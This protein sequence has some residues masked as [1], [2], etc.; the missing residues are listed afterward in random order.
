MSAAELKTLRDLVRNLDPQRL[1]TASF[2]GHDL[3]RDDLRES[4]VTV[5]VDFL[6]PHRPRNAQSPGQTEA[7]TRSRLAMMKEIGRVVPV[8]HQEPFRRGYSQWEPVAGDFLTDLRGAIAGGAAGWCFHNGQQRDTPDKEPRRSFDLRTRRLFDQLDAEELKV[9]ADARALLSGNGSGP[10]FPLKAGPTKR[11]LVDQTGRP[12]FINGDTPWS[13]ASRV[14]R[15]DVELYLKHRA[16]LGVNSLIITIPEGYYCDGCRDEDGPQDFYGEKPFLT[17]NKFTT[18]NPKYFGH[19]D[20]VIR[21]AGD[22]GMQVLMCP[23]Y[24]GYDSGEKSDG[25]YVALAREYS[26]ADCRWYGEWMGARYK[27]FPN[28]V[29]VTGNDRD[30]GDLRKKNERHRGR[31]PV[32]GPRPFDDLSRETR[33]FLS[34][35]VAAGPV[36]LAHLEWDL[37]VRRRL[38]EI[39]RRLQP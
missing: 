12:I 28:L 38:E 10:A 4:L 15:E 24:T 18:P 3:S 8:H 21:R 31:H 30:P 2:G 5:G 36:S 35:R 39:S 29:Y 34:G 7:R 13:L 23:M 25:W 22:F 33:S 1:V 19:A 32:A 9:V 14:S 6:S 27:A 37:P 11:Y 26:V 20:W 16:T 17:K